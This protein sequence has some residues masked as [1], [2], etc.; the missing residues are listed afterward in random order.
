[1]FKVTL[2]GK[3]TFEEQACQLIVKPAKGEAQTFDFDNTKSMAQAIATAI[4]GGNMSHPVA[5]QIAMLMGIP[6]FE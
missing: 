2:S 3:G 6:P 5:N 1:M 4:R